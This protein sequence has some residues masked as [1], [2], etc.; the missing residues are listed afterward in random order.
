VCRPSETRPGHTETHGREN[1]RGHEKREKRTIIR[2]DKRTYNLEEDVAKQLV[3]VPFGH[4]RPDV[5]QHFPIVIA[6]H[7]HRRTGVRWKDSRAEET[8]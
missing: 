7:L 5:S 8:K 1:S 6:N 2:C 4:P 3:R